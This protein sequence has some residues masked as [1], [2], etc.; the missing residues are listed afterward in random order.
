MGSGCRA[1]P[2]PRL[3]APF[4][5]WRSRPAACAVGR[6]RSRW[7]I[8]GSAGSSGSA[9]P[10]ISLSRTAGAFL[11]QPQPQG[12]AS[13]ALRRRARPLQFHLCRRGSA[14]AFQAIGSVSEPAGAGQYQDHRE[15]QPHVRQNG[16][17]LRHANAT[18]PA[19]AAA[20]HQS[21]IQGYPSVIS[22]LK[23]L[24]QLCHNILKRLADP[25]GFER[26]TS[27]FGSKRSTSENC[28]EA[29]SAFSSSS[30]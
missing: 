28:S 22:I 10:S 21:G 13:T 9:S 12:P 24:I 27:A 29:A 20:R 18:G 3:G 1:R 11:P 4:R 17:P 2:E 7:L 15:G 6:P 23:S 8:R 25:T 26:A 14:R 30:K 5:G 19:A 16:C